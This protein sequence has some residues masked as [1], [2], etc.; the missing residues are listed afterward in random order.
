M[1]IW[2]GLLHA[3][4]RFQELSYRYLPVAHVVHNAICYL[5]GNKGG[6]S[7]KDR[8]QSSLK[9][10][11]KVIIEKI[12]SNI[13]RME[14]VNSDGWMRMREENNKRLQRNHLDELSVKTSTSTQ[15][16]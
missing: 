8:E 5:N 13:I 10:D 9:N 2:K 3:L 7:S 1:S 14:V 6:P 15:L 16:P 12:L 11:T 4:I